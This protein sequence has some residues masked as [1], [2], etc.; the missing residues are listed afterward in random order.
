VKVGDLVTMPGQ[1]LREGESASVAVVL[2][3]DSEWAKMT[4]HLARVKVYWIQDEEMAW[5]PREWLEVVSA[6]R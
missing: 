4:G 6:N 2:K 5:E 3:T 1:K